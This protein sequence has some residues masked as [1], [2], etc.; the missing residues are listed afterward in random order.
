ML[1]A[2][3]FRD[4]VF[5]LFPLI[6]AKTTEHKYKTGKLDNPIKYY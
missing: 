2:R 3:R 5:N 4:I 1:P 6:S